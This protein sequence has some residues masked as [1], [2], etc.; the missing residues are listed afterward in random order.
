MHF[1][2]SGFLVLGL[3]TGAFAT[4]F[5]VLQGGQPIGPQPQEIQ[6]ILGT[7]GEESRKA[8]QAMIEKYGQPH[9]VALSM[10]IWHDN[11]PWLRTI[12]YREEVQ[13]NFPMEHVDVLEQFVAFKVPADKFSELAQYDGSVICERTKG[14]LSARCD[15]EAAN[16]LALNLAHDIIEGERDVEEARQ[17]YAE[18]MAR[19]MAGEQHEYLEGLTFEPMSKEE[20]RDPDQPAKITVRTREAGAPRDSDDDK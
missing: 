7:W 1:T 6:R 8:A 16:F 5:V 3:L 9:E 11:D 4:P 10:F 17:F 12:V 18:T 19:M 20:A 14:E 13:H 15:T 2:R